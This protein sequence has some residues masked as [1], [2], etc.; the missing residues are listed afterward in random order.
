VL[1]VA[2][3]PFDTVTILL[4]SIGIKVFGFVLL[5]YKSNRAKKS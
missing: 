2:E 5:Q 1:R 4:R 3:L